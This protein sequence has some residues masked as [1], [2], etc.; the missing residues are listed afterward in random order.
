MTRIFTAALL[1]LVLTACATGG[2]A[3]PS[4]SESPSAPAPTASPEGPA[5][6]DAPSPSA[7]PQWE[8]DPAA[9]LALVQFPIPDSPASQVFV[10]E[11]D[12]GMR[13]VT[14]S[15]TSFNGAT[16]PVWSP[17][18][19][20]IA[21]S[22]PKVG[23]DGVKGEIGVV[24]ANGTGE[25]EIS[26]GR[27]VSWSPDGTMIL[28]G[29]V[30]DVTSDPP[31]MYVVDVATGEV[32]DVGIG[33]QP[34]WLPDGE[35]FSF[36]RNV[37]GRVPDNEEAFSTVLFVV[38]LDGS[39]QTEIAEDTEGYW[40]PDGS[41]ML[42]VHEGTISLAEPDGTDA[43]EI[44][45]GFQPVWSP[46]G[47]RILLEYAHDEN[48]TPILAVIDLDGERIWSD[49]PGTFPSWSPDGTRIAIEIPYPEPMVQVLDA[50]T[51][52]VLWE[53][54]GSSPAWTN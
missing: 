22:G 43:R 29:E 2:A 16:L 10:V 52:D 33:Y 34:R 9:G 4:A 24:N 40:S 15:S 5:D 18:R 8:G 27:D 21:F 46:D 49:V 36:Y 7:A 14:G 3:S 38:A 32:T 20:Q 28:V 35:R 31:S 11:D 13:Q 45:D 25:R 50:A 30:D 51:G 41:A 54:E 44:A 47:T 53:V 39:E 12:G 1:V 48:A 19:A 42:L 17:D 23:G 6:S 37:Q 26:E